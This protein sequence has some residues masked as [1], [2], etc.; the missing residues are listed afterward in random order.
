MINAE[1]FYTPLGEIDINFNGPIESFIEDNNIS[2]NVENNLVYPEGRLIFIKNNKRATY[3]PASSI[4]DYPTE[5]ILDH[6]RE[7]VSLAGE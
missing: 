1:V 7:L 4:N 3:Y 2:Y 5:V 6:L